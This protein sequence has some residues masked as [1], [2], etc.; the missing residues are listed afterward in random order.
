MLVSVFK[1]WSADGVTMMS[2]ASAYYLMV[3]LAPLLFVLAIVADAIVSVISGV[4][5]VSDE[6]AQQLSSPAS[7][8]MNSVAERYF[9][10]IGQKGTLIALGIALFGATVFMAAFIKSLDRIFGPGKSPTKGWKAQLRRRL[11]A[12][13]TLV[14]VVVVMIAS[15]TVSRILD[16]LIGRAEEIL[17]TEV[18]LPS[19]ISFLLNAVFWVSIV[20]L[21]FLVTFAFTFLPARRIKW[22]DSF[23]GAALT[24]GAVLI[25]QQLLSIYLERSSLI[26]AFGAMSAFLA[27][28]IWAYYTMLVILTGAEFTSVWAEDAEKRREAS[29]DLQPVSNGEAD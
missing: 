25:G 18:V 15:M 23:E 5:V 6:V 9:Q 4:G 12:L 10:T 8:Q 26:S 13:A 17:F 28:M 21:F 20:T 11:L 7:A 14:V 16:Q 22:R 2:A 29:A 3:T 27:F 24:T 1:D 19:S